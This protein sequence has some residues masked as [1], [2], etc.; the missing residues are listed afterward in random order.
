[1][2]QALELDA[3]G[4]RH[5]KVAGCSAVTGKGLLAAFEWLVGDVQSR[6][7]LLD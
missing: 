7:Y 6:I 3:M 4:T 1:M 2:K 5:W